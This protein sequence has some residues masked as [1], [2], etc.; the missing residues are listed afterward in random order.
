MSSPRSGDSP[1]AVDAETLAGVFQQRIAGASHPARQPA[2]AAQTVDRRVT[3]QASVRQWPSAHRQERLGFAQVHLP[4]PAGPARDLLWTLQ[5]RFRSGDGRFRAS[6]QIGSHATSL[7]RF[8]FLA[9]DDFRPD[10]GQ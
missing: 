7:P 4:G 1:A 8:L 10:T 6:V 9:R 3:G 2:A 5:Q